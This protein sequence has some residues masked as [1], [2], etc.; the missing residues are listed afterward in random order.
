[1]PEMLAVAR[2]FGE[3]CKLRDPLHLRNLINLAD[4]YRL[5][6]DSAKAQETWK[7]AETLDPDH[8]TVQKLKT[9]LGAGRSG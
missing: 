4:I 1:K 8:A 7:R 5:M 9:L 6:G 3:R 2:S